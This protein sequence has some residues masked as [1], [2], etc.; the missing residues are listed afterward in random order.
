MHGIMCH[1]FLC[2][3]L[4]LFFFC[5]TACAGPPGVSV[6]EKIPD[7]EASVICEVAATMGVTPEAVSNFILLANTTGLVTEAYTAAEADA[8][9]DTVEKFVKEG[10]GSGLTYSGLIQAA[11]AYH[12]TLTPKM[13]AT[14]I[15]MQEFMEVPEVPGGK[16]LTGYDYKLIFAALEKQRRVVAPFLI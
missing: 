4:L 13:Q 2:L 11:L 7:G 14:F 16:I 12:G 15:V 10:Q 8:V 9:L 3:I 5:L 1:R 6:C